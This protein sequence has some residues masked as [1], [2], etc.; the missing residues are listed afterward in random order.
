MRSSQNMLLVL[1]ESANLGVI[2]P[3]RDFGS[4]RCNN[5]VVM[6]N[7]GPTRMPFPQQQ[8]RNICQYF[9]MYAFKGYQHI[10]KDVAGQDPVLKHQSLC[11]PNSALCMEASTITPR[12]HPPYQCCRHPDPFHLRHQSSCSY[13]GSHLAQLHLW[14]CHQPQSTSRS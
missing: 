4:Q 8:M 14:P 6:E 12:A 1:A 10:M 2:N 7:V 3:S 11:S 9:S 13:R 5:E